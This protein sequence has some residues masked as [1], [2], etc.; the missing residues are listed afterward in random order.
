[1]FGLGKNKRKNK[2]R[3]HER[4][5]L[6]P[7]QGGRARMRKQRMIMRWTIATGLLFSFLVAC[8]LYVMHHL[9]YRR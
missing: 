7:G 5:Y 1:M 9:Q 3:K 4:F 6:L 2:D 8:L